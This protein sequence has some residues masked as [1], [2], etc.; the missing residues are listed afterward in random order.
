MLASTS[1]KRRPWTRSRKDEDVEAPLVERM[2]PLK[3]LPFAVELRAVPWACRD[4]SVSGLGTPCVVL[5]GGPSL[6]ARYGWHVGLGCSVVSAFSFAFL[7]PK[8][9]PRYGHCGFAVGSV[10]AI[11]RS[12]FLVENVGLG[13]VVLYALLVSCLLGALAMTALSDPGMRPRPFPSRRRRGGTE[14]RR[15]VELASAPTPSTT[16]SP[17][18]GKR[19]PRRHRRHTGV[20]CADDD[21]AA[22]IVDLARRDHLSEKTFCPTCLIQRP[23][24][25]KHDPTLKAVRERFDHYCPFVATVVGERNYRYFYAF[26]VF[27]V[28]AISLHLLLVLPLVRLCDDMNGKSSASSAKHAPIFIG[29][30]LAILHDVWIACMLIMHSSLVCTDQTTYEQMHG[31]EGGECAQ[32]DA[33]RSFDPSPPGKLQRTALLEGG[34]EQP[35]HVVLRR[36]LPNDLREALRDD[37]ALVVGDGDVGLLQGRPVGREGVAVLERLEVVQYTLAAAVRL[38]LLHPHVADGRVDDGVDDAT[39]VVLCQGPCL[40][41]AHGGGACAVLSG[42]WLESLPRL[43]SRCPFSPRRL[44]MS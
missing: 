41:L 31:K 30:I 10:L 4:R 28:L 15:R 25:A 35:E 14:S 1:S 17:R 22:K 27:C 36:L 39:H 24:R 18:R 33:G 26:L 37:L 20:V 19:R 5:L 34:D 21:R 3:P 13:L 12:F 23:A 7:A 11:V 2:A 16:P 32:Q 44:R 9:A 38:R 42:V 40:G 6:I 29:T 43:R 8:D